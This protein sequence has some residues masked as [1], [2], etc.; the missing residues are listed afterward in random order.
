M[1]TVETLVIGAGVVGLSVA[2]ALSRQGHEVVIAEA[3]DAFGTETS[4]R[5]SEVIH[6][7]IYYP[8]GSLKARLC[9]AGRDALYAYCAASKVQARRI[10]KL[11]VATDSSQEPELRAIQ[12]KAAENGVND[13]LWLT[14]AEARA[15]EPELHC[16]AALLSPST[17]IIDSHGLMLSY[18]GE[19][20]ANGAMLALKSPVLGGAITDAG[21]VLDIGGTTPMRL[22]ARHVINAAGLQA[23]IIARKIQGLAPETIPPNFYAKGNYFVLSGVKPPFSRL[24]YPVP[25]PGGLGIHVTL[26]LAGQMRF[27]PDV[28]WID[29]LDYD[30]SVD[31]ARGEKFYAAVRRYWPALPDGAIQPGYAGIRPK[32][33]HGGSKA[34]DFVIQG[35]A[36]HGVR[37]LI[38]LFGIESPGLTSSLALGHYVADL[39]Q[40]DLA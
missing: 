16:T 1:E 18:L 7:G 32:L 13:L 25:E 12:R 2:R 21:I 34:D 38:N 8:T 15:L 31:P 24:V 35:R 20:E 40:A 4:A 23:Q 27:G 30:Y 26:D 6:A 29:H 3:A 11:I 22:Q 10:G 14:A 28:Q 37:G 9:V 33:S 17:G 39:L 19:A 5:N 36:I